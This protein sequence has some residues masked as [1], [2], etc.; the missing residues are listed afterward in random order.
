[1]TST[2]F[3]ATAA[4]ATAAFATASAGNAGFV[5]HCDRVSFLTKDR[6]YAR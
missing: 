2:A 1:M 6:T 4:S 3:T 5:A